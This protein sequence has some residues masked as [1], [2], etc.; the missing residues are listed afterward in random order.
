MSVETKSLEMYEE[1]YGGEEHLVTGMEG[2]LQL[3]GLQVFIREAKKMIEKSSPFFSQASLL[4]IYYRRQLA[5]LH[6]EA[7]I[8]SLHIEALNTAAAKKLLKSFGVAGVGINLKTGDVDAKITEQILAVHD[9]L[10]TDVEATS[11]ELP[12]S[13]ANFTALI[14]TIQRE[15]T[16][17]LIASQK[18]QL[19]ELKIKEEEEEKVGQHLSTHASTTQVVI[20]D[21]VETSLE[22]QKERR[23][24][25]SK[26]ERSA[27]SQLKTLVSFAEEMFAPVKRGTQEMGAITA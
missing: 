4:F 23:K 24:E 17:L 22:A 15:I 10:V 9:G 26:E 6:I 18:F 3:T 12:A 7:L 14:A 20:Y 21:S 8:A 19:A 11:A 27:L 2:I 5:N 25:N 13:I 1:F 16:E